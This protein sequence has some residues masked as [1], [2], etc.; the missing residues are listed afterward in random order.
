A[1]KSFVEKGIDSAT[2]QDIATEAGISAGA[3]YRYFPGKEQVLKGVLEHFHE[4]NR[5]MFARARAEAS[6]P[7]EALQRAAFMALDDHANKE[8][9]ALWM[10]MSLA[11][12]RYGLAEQ[13]IDCWT[14]VGDQ[15]EELVREAQAA[16]QIDPSLDS[17]A[18]ALLFLATVKG[19]MALT[20]ELNGS[21]DI[22]MFKSMVQ[23]MVSRFAPARSA[24]AAT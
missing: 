12:W 23:E 21:A 3:I 15:I 5:Q 13:R 8:S 10:E 24:V 2:V 1:M 4:E 16:G 18:V 17:Q 6:S 20:F 14:D 9:C 19:I 22:S 7:L 11:S